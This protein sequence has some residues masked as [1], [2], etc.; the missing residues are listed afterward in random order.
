MRDYFQN[1]LGGMFPF[2]TLEEVSKQNIAM[3][4]RAMR[5]FSPFG[6]QGDPGAPGTPAAPPKARSEEDR[7]GDL[8]KKLDELQQ[9]L[10][11]LTKK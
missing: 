1:T 7:L 8:Q 11:G 4:E 9:Q 10:Q 6:D 2:G 3:F 5:M